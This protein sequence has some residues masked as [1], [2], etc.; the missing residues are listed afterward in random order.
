MGNYSWLLPVQASSFAARIDLGLWIIHAAMI[1]I[2]VLWTIFF[3]Y[4][5]VAYR[6]RD[7]HKAERIHIDHW[8]SLAPDAAV[9]FFEL[10]VVALYV[11]PTWS[12]LKMS[13]PDEK[14]SIVVNIVAEQFNWNVHYPGPD[15]KFGKRSAALID[16]SNPLGIDPT[17][18]A[19]ADDFVTVNDMHFP[20]GKPVLARLSSKDVIHSFFIPAFRIKQDAVPG[21]VVPLWFEPTLEGDYEVTCAQLCGVGHAIMRADVKVQSRTDYDR[22]F[23]S[24]A[25]VKKAGPSGATEEW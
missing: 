8:K 2:F 14:D 17:D 25:P 13:L 18:P 15:G 23:A 4:L 7:G 1:L 11:I 12:S 10:S 19:G 6:Q 20:V 9:L 24:M 3:A 5:L 21:M 22:W 16:F